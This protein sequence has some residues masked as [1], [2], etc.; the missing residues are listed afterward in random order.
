[1]HRA[2]AS[3][4]CIIAARSHLEIAGGFPV[5]ELAGQLQR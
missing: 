5:A 3:I 4:S 1:M 2:E